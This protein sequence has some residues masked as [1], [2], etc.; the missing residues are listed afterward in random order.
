MGKFYNPLS[1]KVQGKP[2]LVYIDGEVGKLAN[3]RTSRSIEK[4]L[5]RLFKNNDLANKGDFFITIVWKDGRDLMYDVWMYS[6]LQQWGAGALV[7]VQN[8]RNYQRDTKS[9]VSAEH[10]LI[11]LGE[12]AQHRLGSKGTLDDYVRGSR[13]ELPRY[14]RNFQNFYV[15]NAN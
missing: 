5:G 9:G 8:F 10:G 7:D 6:Q 15:K 11:M 12:E 14:T 2:V 4:R 1:R 13:P 3:R